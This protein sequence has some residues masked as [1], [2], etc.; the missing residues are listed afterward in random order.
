MSKARKII[1]TTIR[2]VLIILFAVIITVVNT[3]LPNYARM[4]DSMIGGINTQID[5]SDVDTTG[6][7][8]TY[9]EA[10]YT[11][12]SIKEAE[13]ALHQQIADEGTVLLSNEGI[14][15]M[16]QDTEFSFFSVNSAT[17]SASDSMLGGRNL[18][19]IFEDAGA[20]INTTLMD[21][22]SEQ[23]KEYGLSSGSISFGDAEDFAIHEVPLS[24]LQ[25]NTEVM[26]SVKNTVPVYFLKR[27]AGEGRDMPRSMYNHAESEEDKAK[28]YL[29]PD[30][31]ELEIISYLNDN[32]DNVDRKSVV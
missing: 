22:Y 24:V 12:D 15:P 3:I 20:K 14:L 2:S 13:A 21:F 9:N 28:S 31:T 11:T 27:V 18:T 19:Q 32:F 17:V 25:E 1:G 4:M 6:L 23:S 10:D 16:A 8:L 30:S 7:D 26:D 5:N 29:E